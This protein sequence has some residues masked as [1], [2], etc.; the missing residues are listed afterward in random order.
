MLWLLSGLFLNL[1]ATEP[2]T[3]S[4]GIYQGT[5]ISSVAVQG[6][7]TGLRI[8]ADSLYFTVTNLEGCVF[9]VGADSILWSEDGMV[10]SR[11]ANVVIKT[12]EPGGTMKVKSLVPS[13]KE[14]IIHA[15]LDLALVSD[16]LKLLAYT[17]MNDYLSGVIRAE[18]GSKP[19]LEYAKVQAIIS[20]TYALS[21]LRNHE[22]EG[23]QLCDQTH[24][25]VYRGWNHEFPEL[26]RAV[27]ETHG[28]VLID[29]HAQFVKAVFSANCGGQTMNSEDV[30]D[31]P[32]SYLRS[33]QDP[34]CK[35]S[36]TYRYTVEKT[37]AEWSRAMKTSYKNYTK[38]Q[39][40]LFSKGVVVQSVRKRNYELE[41]NAV[42]LRVLR[43]QLKLKST[44]F[45]ASLRDGTILIQGRG[46]GHGVGL[47]QEGA[48]EMARQGFSY[49]EILHFYFTHVSLI[50][51][52]EREY[53]LFE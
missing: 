35:N 16:G 44:W 40:P 12:M 29:Q 15:R 46:F 11:F 27:A 45:D 52:S 28:L 24:C 41:K 8:E 6:L 31:R 47:C 14:R 43:E 53:F 25:Q 26:E 17:P 2:D 37:P 13:A 33:V 39:D 19:P 1:S 4:I 38:D 34:Y 36:A 10:C 51:M 18:A 20:R 48:M 7:G 5:R 50:D 22:A 9:T 32:L 21:H 49:R 30:W 42:P 23:F 3:L